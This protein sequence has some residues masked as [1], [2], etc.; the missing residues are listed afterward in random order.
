MVNSIVIVGST[1]LKTSEYYKQIGI[2]SSM[3]IT[4]RDHQQ[5]IGHTSVG[6][7]PDLK[8]LEYIL[9][10]AT[11]V[12]WAESSIDEFFDA[13]SYYDFVNWLKDYNLIYNNVV[14]LH[15]IKFD[16]YNWNHL[17][18][19]NLNQNH[20]V[21]FG[22]SFTA[23]AG[24][25][26]VETHYT[27][28][29]AKHFGKQVFNLGSNGGSNALVFDQFTQLD[30]FPGQIVVVQLT[31]L[32]RL[33]YCGL[34]RQLTKVVFTKKN[35]ENLIHNLVEIYNK[36]FLFYELL[37][38]IRAMVAIARAKKLKMVFWLINYKDT[39]IYS[40]A[41]QRYFYH[42]PEFVPASWMENYFLDL[43]TDGQHPGIRSNKFIADT[44]VK[45]IESVYNKE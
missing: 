19:Q 45:Y 35:Y 33:H 39:K 13:D 2:A 22:C 27:T 25:P 3:L 21:F 14:N 24:L 10:Q 43:A 41:D 17:L 16:D 31:F 28:Q 30:F 1:D 7:V 23:G 36:D 9:S 6:D 8:D 11:E 34:N 40:K 12:Y 18:S 38:K 42:M 26:D 44:L 32:E 15:K 37:Q 5:L 20:V 29:V 4:S